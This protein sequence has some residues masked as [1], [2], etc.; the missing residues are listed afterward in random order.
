MEL[1]P[2]ALA[3]QSRALAHGVDGLGEAE[4]VL[5]DHPGVSRTMTDPDDLFQRVVRV[6]KPWLQRSSST[7]E[8]DQQMGE[9]VVSTSS[10]GMSEPLSLEVDLQ[11]TGG[12]GWSVRYP[13]ISILHP[14]TYGQTP[15]SR[16]LLLNREA[17]IDRAAGPHT[18]GRGSGSPLRLTTILAGLEALLDDHLVSVLLLDVELSPLERVGVFSGVAFGHEGEILAVDDRQRVA[19]DDG[20]AFRPR[21]SMRIA[22][23]ISRPRGLSR[24]S[25]ANSQGPGVGIDVGNTRPWFRTHSWRT[26]AGCPTWPR[27]TLSWSLSKTLPDPEIGH[28]REGEYWS[29]RRSRLPRRDRRRCR[30]SARAPSSG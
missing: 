9:G 3:R 24:L 14:P 23:T 15:T 29:G 17:G 11:G 16:L 26:G 19:G 6:R 28:R 27:W 30:R 25:I 21:N 1:V 7:Q 8:A 20:V 4:Q 13:L 2:W 10:S 12:C 22:W 5:R 18:S